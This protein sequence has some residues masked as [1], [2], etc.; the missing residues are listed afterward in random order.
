MTE[1]HEQARGMLRSHRDMLDR[2]SA[3][4]LEKEVIDADEL[5]AILGVAPKDPETIPA[6]IPPVG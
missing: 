5:K 4:L 3:G 1:A 6:D 2:L